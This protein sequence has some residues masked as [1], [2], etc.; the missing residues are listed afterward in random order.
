MDLLLN[1]RV[2]KNG[3]LLL[4]AAVAGPAMILAGVRYPGSFQAKAF[5]S[6]TG[7]AVSGISYYYLSSDVR[8][9]LTKTE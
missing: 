8:P 6:L 3:L 1:P 9:L 4:A 7:V 5:L 2:Q